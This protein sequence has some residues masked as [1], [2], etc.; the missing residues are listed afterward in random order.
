MQGKTFAKGVG[1]GV[2]AGSL[3]TAAMIPMDKKRV[4]CKKPNRALK[5]MGQVVGGIC[6]AFTQ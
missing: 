5:T 3:L 2:I 4:M 1:I 6:D